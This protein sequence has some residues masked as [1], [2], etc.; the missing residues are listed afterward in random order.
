MVSSLEKVG[1]TR[2]HSRDGGGGRGRER[3]DDVREYE[4]D[5]DDDHRNHSPPS[6]RSATY[7]HDDGDEEDGDSETTSLSELEEGDETGEEL[8]SG[9][10]RNERQLERDGSKMGRRRIAQYEKRSYYN[11]EDDDHDDDEEDEGDVD[12]DE[13]LPSMNRR[14]RRRRAALA[15][16]VRE[17]DI[18]GSAASAGADCHDGRRRDRELTEM[19]RDRLLAE[20]GR[21]YGQHNAIVERMTNIEREVAVRRALMIANGVAVGGGDD[22]PGVADLLL[23]AD[24]GM[25]GLPSVHD[26]AR[27][28]SD[29]TKL[30]PMHSPR[31]QRAGIWKDKSGGWVEEV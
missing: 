4:D 27:Y 8:T 24:G 12:N 14:R 25:M 30:L 17:I 3:G 22:C 16:P 26:G 2:H 15:R 19:E 9:I 10:R 20:Y 31:T 28:S 5:D 1:Q 13:E 6:G 11:R 7:S 21:L 23:R 18:V 29:S